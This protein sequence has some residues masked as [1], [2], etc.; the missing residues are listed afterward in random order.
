MKYPGTI[1]CS[2]LTG[3]GVGMIAYLGQSA[4]P[5]FPFWVAIWAVLLLA[6]M[7]FFVVESSR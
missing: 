3:A 4:S 5:F 6:S 7:A 1:V 2:L